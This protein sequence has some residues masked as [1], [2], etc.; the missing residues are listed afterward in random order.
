MSTTSGVVDPTD[1]GELNRLQAVI[2]R[3][4]MAEGAGHIVHDLPVRSDGRAVGIAS[5]PWRLDPIPYVIEADDFLWIE[6]AVRRR[7][8]MLEALLTDLYGERRIVADGLIDPAEL[9]G[10]DRYRL[11]AVGSAERRDQHR[12]L[13]TYAVDVVRTAEGAWYATADHTD[14]PSGLGY[15]LLDRAVFDQTLDGRTGPARPIA[16]ALGAIRHAITDTASV[17]GPRVVV[18]T[19]GIDHPAYVEH[20]YLATQLGFN[21][22]EGAD[23]VVRDR[24][25]WLQT[26]GGLEPIDVLYRRLSDRQL[27]PMETNATGTSGIPGV[28]LAD[29]SDALAMAN[30]HGTGLIEDRRLAARWDA[31]GAALTGEDPWLTMVPPGAG[32]IDVLL[33]APAERVD[34]F[35][36][37]IVQQLPIVLRFHAVASDDGIVVVPTA[38]GRVLFP[39]DDPLKPTPC[40]AKDTWVLGDAALPA[41]VPIRHAPQVDLITSVPTRAAD[42]LYWLC[43][44]AERAEAV[45]RTCRVVAAGRGVAGIIDDSVAMHL[46]DA[47]T[48]PL[49]STIDTKV[50]PP[51]TAVNDSILASAAASLDFHLGSMLAESAS[52][53]EFLSTTTGRVLGEMVESR[54]RLSRNPV[55][56]DALDGVLM[57]LSAFSGLWSESVVRGPAWYFGDFARRY[58]RAVVAL[59]GAAAA[60]RCGEDPDR[61]EVSQARGLEA[62]LA[63]NDS[64]VAY[65]RR[66]RSEV[67]LDAVWGLL[68]HD[69]RNPRSA[70]ASIAGLERNAT[71]IGWQKGVG[72]LALIRGSLEQLEGS[73][74][75]RP[76]VFETIVQDLHDAAAELTRTRLVAPPHPMLVRAAVIDPGAIA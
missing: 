42:S 24:H 50:G 76:A 54:T 57:Q 43:R 27:D 28:L 60:A 23:L 47:L 25:L 52:V 6:E 38:N 32:G 29:E 41:P 45:A 61:D 21:L 34:V 49:D 74:S 65:R 48:G 22:V 66:H 70:A 5:R 71:A 72:S 4:L 20:S 3:L 69:P 12:W 40:M 36:D 53:R 13:S 14:A 16:P 31:A 39:S 58:E 26:L 15:A 56:I 30:A 19:A 73:E 37:G 35:L 8:V 10:S 68:L 62:I 11:A 67:E 55:D 2:D 9:W 18:F 17:E 75:I 59:S 64:L 46:L 1:F 51:T 63:A 7:M 44:A 33:G